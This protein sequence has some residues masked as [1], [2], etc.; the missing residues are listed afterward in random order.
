MYTRSNFSWAGIAI[1][2]AKGVPA[3]VDT[4]LPLAGAES[5][6]RNWDMQYSEVPDGMIWDVWSVKRG[7]WAQGDLPI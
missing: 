5:L 4:A 7:E 3:T 2:S 1:Q 6:E